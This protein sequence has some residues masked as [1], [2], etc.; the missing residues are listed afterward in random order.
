MEKYIGD[1]RVI[2]MLAGLRFL[3]KVDSTYS[4]MPQKFSLEWD[5]KGTSGSAYYPDKKSRDAMY[6]KVSKALTLQ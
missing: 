5:Y 4:G 6:D 1:D 3:K 2:L